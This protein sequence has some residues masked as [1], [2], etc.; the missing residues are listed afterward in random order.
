MPSITLSKGESLYS[1]GEVTEGI[2]QV[3]SGKV[4][5][6]SFSHSG[7]EHILSVCVPPLTFGEASLIS[8]EPSIFTVIAMEKSVVAMLEKSRFNQLRE[9]HPEINQVL[10]KNACHRQMWTYKMLETSAAFDLRA[11]LAERLHLLSQTI[12]DPLAENAIMVPIKQEDL[13]NMLGATR[14]SINQLL[15]EWESVGN[16]KI[17]YGGVK[18][19]RTLTI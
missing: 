2:Y 8:S 12:G 14:Q 16:L 5:L 10:L 11:R 3:I 15:S 13:A 18:I 1:T 7:K 17:V 19:M 4:K 9:V 6:S